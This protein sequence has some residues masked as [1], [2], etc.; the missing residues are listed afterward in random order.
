[1]WWDPDPKD[2]E[3]P[4][5]GQTLTHG[6]GKLSYAQCQ[7]LTQAVD[8]LLE[9]Y[10]AYL[11]LSLRLGLER[12][13]SLPSTYVRAVINVTNVQRSYLELKGMISY[14]TVYK[15]RIEDPSAEPGLP[16]DCV[17]VT[18]LDPAGMIELEAAHG[19][20]PVPVGTDMEKRMRSLHLCTQS[21]P[22][23]K[24]PFSAIP[25]PSFDPNHQ[26]P[27][28]KSMNRRFPRSE[29]LP[30]ARTKDRLRHTDAQP[31]NRA[32]RSHGIP[33]TERDKFILFD[34][35]DM[36]P[37]IA[38][39]ERALS[40]VDRSLPSQCG[41]HP[42]NRYVFP[43]PALLLSAADDGRRRVIIHHYQLMRDA[44]MY[45]LG[46]ASDHPYPL[47]SQEWRDIL[48]GKITR[49]GK[50]GTRAEARSA[51]IETVLGSAMRVC[52]I[53]KFRDFPVDPCDAPW[54]THNR[55]MELVWETAE[56]NFRFELLALDARASGLDRSDERRLCFPAP[57]YCRV[58]HRESKMGSHPCLRRNGSRLMLDWQPRP[59]NEITSYFERQQPEHSTEEIDKLEH[60][61]RI[62]YAMF[63]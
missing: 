15:P 63:L 24:N 60:A 10:T 11:S 58:R 53:D 62:L 29:S 37:G 30:S 57:H 56:I 45:R 13:Q 17:V 14:M 19:F 32:A 21:V 5:S 38:S 39:W 28:L 26:G 3:C 25:T 27:P 20:P 49:Q 12:L 36:P 46:D 52:G 61:W 2:F 50:P 48:H 34:S 23:Y 6:L 7:R 18:P 16:D 35:P 1:M 41:P 4:D 31:K 8:A 33:K 22:W 43:E 54:T 47:K 40:Q 9:E 59:A 55:T 44:L 42:Q 51:S